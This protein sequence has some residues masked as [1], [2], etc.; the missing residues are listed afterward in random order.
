MKSAQLSPP[1][2]IL[3]SLEKDEIADQLQLFLKRAN[4]KSVLRWW[5]DTGLKVSKV[6][7][8]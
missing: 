2:S 1:P 8:R 3:V 6:E 7:R 4:P 5:K